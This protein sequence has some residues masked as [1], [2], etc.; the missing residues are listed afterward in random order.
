MVC[1]PSGMRGI[2]CS[3]QS[4]PARRRAHCVVAATTCP[5]CHNSLST[6][7]ARV[8]FETSSMAE[9]AYWLSHACRRSKFLFIVLL[10]L[11]LSHWRI[12][13][14]VGFHC[15]IVRL[16]DSFLQP[17]GASAT[18]A[19]RQI[20]S[21]QNSCDAALCQE[22]QCI[23]LPALQTGPQTSAEQAHNNRQQLCS[24]SAKQARASTAKQQQHKTHPVVSTHTH[25]DRAACPTAG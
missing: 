14:R 12:E 16:P 7:P 2:E 24:H 25:P 3:L 10:S 15:T 21:V 23:D 22:Q 20:R 5:A 19:S 1:T 11:T 18:S 6:K 4:Q 13:W 9:C 8:L 17:S